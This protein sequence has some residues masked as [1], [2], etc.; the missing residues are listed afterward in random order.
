MSND[1]IRMKQSSAPLGMDE[2]LFKNTVDKPCMGSEGAP[3]LFEMNEPLT[4]WRLPVFLSD[5][6]D[7][8]PKAESFVFFNPCKKCNDLVL[9][10]DG[11]FADPLSLRD[12][13]GVKSDSC[14][15]KEVVVL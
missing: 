4:D 11:V 1:S 7:R 5:A 13:R 8:L 2:T 3:D 6:S 15:D 9:R 10:P 12:R 14:A